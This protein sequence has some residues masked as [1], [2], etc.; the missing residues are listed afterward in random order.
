M[1]AFFVYLHTFMA[2]NKNNPDRLFW[3]VGI[4]NYEN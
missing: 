1:T 2:S 4:S 3:T